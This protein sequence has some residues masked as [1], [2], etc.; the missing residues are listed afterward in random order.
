M[1]TNKKPMTKEDAAR[2]QSH[3]DKTGENQG[4]KGR[5]QKAASKK[6]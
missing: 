2:I 1:S 3:A 4:F 6:K 5:A